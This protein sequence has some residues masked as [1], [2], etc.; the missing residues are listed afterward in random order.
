MLRKILIADD[1]VTTQKE[2]QQLLHNQGYEVLT[3]DTGELAIAK[4]HEFQP[5]MVLLDVI[6]PGKSGYEVCG[7]IKNKPEL[8]QIPVI[9]TFSE[10]EPFD[11]AEARRVGAT[12][13]LPKTIDSDSLITILNFIWAGVTPIEHAQDLSTAQSVKLE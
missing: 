9:L 11:L 1:N 7:Y 4:L 10:N 13:C 2:M 8:N 5:H 6:M 12:R 3:V